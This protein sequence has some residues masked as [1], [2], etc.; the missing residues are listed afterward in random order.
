MTPKK[1][2]DLEGLTKYDDK[3]KELISTKES[4]TVYIT[5]S[6]LS[7]ATAGTLNAQQLTDLKNA[8]SANKNV[9]LVLSVTDS[10]AYKEYFYMCSDR[11]VQGYVSFFSDDV[12]NQ[13]ITHRA[14]SV[15]LSTGSWVLLVDVNS[16]SDNKE[17]IFEGSFVVSGE[18]LQDIVTSTYDLSKR[19]VE[20]L[21]RLGPNSNVA[22]SYIS[23]MIG[24]TT[25]SPFIV[26]YNADDYDTTVPTTRMYVA[27]FSLSSDNKTV[28]ASVGM[29]QQEV[30]FQASTNKLKTTTT[31]YPG[32]GYLE[33]LAIS[34]LPDILY[35]IQGV[36]KF[37]DTITLPDAS[38]L[39]YCSFGRGQ[40]PTSWFDNMLVNKTNLVFRKGTTSTIVYQN[41]TWSGSQIIKFNGLQFVSE[42]FLNWFMAN[43]IAY[44]QYTFIVT[45]GNCSYTPSGNIVIGSGES[46][47][48]T[49][50][51]SAGYK[52]PATVTVIGAS[53]TW[54]QNTG[55]LTLSNPTVN[56]NV[57]VT[58]TQI[59]IAAPTLSISGS[60]LSIVTSDNLPS[61]YTLTAT[62]VGDTKTKSGILKSGATTTFDLSTW[63][64]D[65]GTYTIT[66]VG[67]NSLYATSDSSN[68][69]TYTVAQPQLS[70][71]TNLTADGTTVS[72][73]AVENA[74]SYD[75]YAD[76]TVLL[77]N[78][79]GGAVSSGE[80][81]VLNESLKG[82]VSAE[83]AFTSNS[84][85][86]TNIVASEHTP[87]MSPRPQ[88]HLTY[89]DKGGTTYAVYYDN[90]WQGDA[91][92]RT[93]TFATAPT[94]DLLTW[95]QKN[96]TKQ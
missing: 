31:N 49:F 4:N 46:A 63:L 38:I 8:I 80:T 52:L 18:G 74:E 9:K 24:D 70:A 56:G 2:L 68:A 91:A 32:N 62:G 27:T 90:F 33:I 61:T 84:T 89:F 12:A 13:E 1:Y 93:I 50:T 39:Q 10:P 58:A 37:K 87:E 72:W 41:G 64:T 79:T 53:H 23:T 77:G 96:G 22:Y 59:K 88:I 21:Y 43:A 20:I 48:V 3:I 7:T 47:T 15:T 14:I 51:A 30:A 16:G 60:T 5:V 86:F 34:V 29:S 94:G 85:D 69:V 44:K 45:N 76:D 25:S 82:T 35:T 11:S 57:V 6:V 42:D 73:D 92:Y 81:W 71:P 54:N 83:V 17:V 95:L 65:I 67:V 55:V 75:V 28:T 19:K 26:L 66:A 36:Y 78:T 40:T